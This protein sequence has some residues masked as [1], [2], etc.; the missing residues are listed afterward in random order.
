MLKDSALTWY[1]TQ[2]VTANHGWLQLHNAMMHY[3]KPANYA[4]KTRLALSK[5]RQR[6]SVTNYIVDFSEQHTACN[7]VY[8]NEALFRFLDSLQLYI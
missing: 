1:Y 3:F 8:A 7:N 6:G 5:W 4:F 2:G